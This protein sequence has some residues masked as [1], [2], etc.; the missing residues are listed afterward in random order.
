[1]VLSLERLKDIGGIGIIEFS[2]EDIVRNDILLDIYNKWK[3]RACSPLFPL[4]T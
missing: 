3:K 1:V 4:L 2:D